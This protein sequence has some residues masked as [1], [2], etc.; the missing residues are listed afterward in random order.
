MIVRHE[1]YGPPDPE[2]GIAPLIEVNEV[3][4]PD[5]VTPEPDVSE[6]LGVLLDK[7][8]TATT[9]AQVRAAAKAAAGG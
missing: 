5:D 6:V 3:E 4:Q 7:L 8:A 1:T 9:L 2:T